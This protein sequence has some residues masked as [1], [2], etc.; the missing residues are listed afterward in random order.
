MPTCFIPPLTPC[1][2]STQTPNFTDF[3]HLKTPVTT[4]KTAN[5]TLHL[6]S[7]SVRYNSA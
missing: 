5:G 4:E 7:C 3:T 2:I 1:R 6:P